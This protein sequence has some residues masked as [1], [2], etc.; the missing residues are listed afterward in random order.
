MNQLPYDIDQY[1]ESDLQGISSKLEQIKLEFNGLDQDNDA[2]QLQAIRDELTQIKMSFY[3]LDQDNDVPVLNDIEEILVDIDLRLHTA[4]SYLLTTRDATLNI[5]DNLLA[6][7]NVLDNTFAD[8]T[9]EVTPQEDDLEEVPAQPALNPNDAEP[10]EDPPDMV[11]DVEEKLGGMA[12]NDDFKDKFKPE[13]FVILPTDNPALPTAGTYELGGGGMFSITADIA[14][15]MVDLFNTHAPTI[16]TIITGIICATILLS[17]MNTS[18]I[19]YS[20]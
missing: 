4:N 13:N 20:S 5:K 10:P 8:G 19:M 16:R 17:A 1:F 18:W 9:V 2:D 7:R 15:P 12:Y 3:G 6:M 11:G 14:G